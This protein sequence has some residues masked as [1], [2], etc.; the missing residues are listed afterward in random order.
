MA[1]TVAGGATNK[2]A[3]T[4]LLISAK[5]VRVPPLQGLREARRALERSLQ[6]GWPPQAGRRATGIS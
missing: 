1:L 2:E 3:A 5:T 4:A 6:P